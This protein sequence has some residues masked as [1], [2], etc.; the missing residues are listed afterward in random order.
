MMQ[1]TSCNRHLA[2]D[3]F[4]S[5]SFGTCLLRLYS[6][7]EDPRAWMRCA[8]ETHDGQ[9][10]WCYS[11]RQLYNPLLS[12]HRRHGT[13]PALPRTPSPVCRFPRSGSWLGHTEKHIP[14]KVPRRPLY[15]IRRPF[16]CNTLVR[17]LRFRSSCA[18][19]HKKNLAKDAGPEVARHGPM[20][21]FY[22]PRRNRHLQNSAHP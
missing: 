5:T 1:S 18:L 14:K 9:L 3:I 16:L 19:L 8:F 20:L 7:D 6:L 17:F 11:T 13:P 2:I 15:L 21:Q 10:L 22:S 12:H 4:Q